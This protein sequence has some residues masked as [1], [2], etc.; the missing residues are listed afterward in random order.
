MPLVIVVF[1]IPPQP[2]PA[3]RTPRDRR[4]ADARARSGRR[5]LPHPGT[6]RPPP[7]G[8]TDGIHVRRDDPRRRRASF[9]ARLAAPRQPDAEYP[10]GSN[11]VGCVSVPTSTDCAASSR[12]GSVRPDQCRPTRNRLRL[13]GSRRRRLPDHDL[14]R[15]RGAHGHRP[16]ALL[17][18]SLPR[19]ACAYDTLSVTA[20]STPVT[21]LPPDIEHSLDDTATRLTTTIRFGDCRPNAL[22]TAASERGETQ[23]RSPNAPLAKM[24]AQRTL[25]APPVS[26]SAPPAPCGSSLTTASAGLSCSP[27]DS[28]R[29]A[30]ASGCWALTVKPRARRGHRQTSAEGLVRSS[31]HGRRRA[32]TRH[33][34][35][36]PR[37]NRQ[38]GKDRSARRAPLTA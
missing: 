22:V 11:T 37:P 25:T 17:H 18:R 26:H 9:R 21:G 3:R 7:G 20:T 33:R 34:L 4:C 6:D 2:L 15:H 30:T 19:P 14:R 16:H 8:S 1:A 12:A 10:G 24:I 23:G 35:P 31:G 29:A 32:A 27:S 36:S 13:C 28:A 38:P 5:Q